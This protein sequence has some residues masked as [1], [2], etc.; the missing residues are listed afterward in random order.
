MKVFDII[1]EAE[2]AT[3]VLGSDGKMIMKTVPDEVGTNAKTP[4]STSSSNTS[5]KKTKVPVKYDPDIPTRN[6]LTR[7]QVKQMARTGKVT[8]GGKTFTKKQ[9]AKNTALNKTRLVALT[10][11]PSKALS[12]AAKKEIGGAYKKSSGMFAKG[13]PGK[14]IKAPPSI[15]KGILKRTPIGLAI[16]SLIG[17]LEAQRILEKWGENFYVNGCKK[18][19]HD[20]IPGGTAESKILV[21]NMRELQL[22]MAKAVTVGVA[23]LFSGLATG[24]VGFGKIAALVAKVIPPIFPF[25]MIAKGLTIAASATL[26]FGVAYMFS[27]LAKA[28]GIHDKLGLWMA[29]NWFTSDAM[30]R[31]AD[32]LATNN[33]CERTQ[34]DIDNWATPINESTGDI[35]NAIKAEFKALMK[36]PKFKRAVKRVKDAPNPKS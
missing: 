34:E 3:G 4:S 14:F 36:D 9:I 7:G 6:K 26:T 28:S 29:Q 15:L 5:A 23:G 25:G 10:K 1:S 27:R 31:Y 16:G 33:N 21:D 30:E 19:V 17:M 22:E 35:E 24:A 12:K 20:G 18:T 11:D 2:V 8:V 13:K 32:Y